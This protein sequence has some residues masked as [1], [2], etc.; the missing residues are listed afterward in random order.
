MLW[1]KILALL[2]YLLGWWSFAP[3]DH[4]AEQVTSNAVSTVTRAGTYLGYRSIP[5]GAR[6]GASHPP[7]TPKAFSGIHVISPGIFPLMQ[8]EGKFSMVDVYLDVAAGQIVRG[9]DH[10][11]SRLI[12]VGKPES[13]EQAENLF[14]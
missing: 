2:G 11:G 6:A 12:D 5:H 13:V 7:L 8:R 1:K 10:S 4:E 14:P 3:M 9:F